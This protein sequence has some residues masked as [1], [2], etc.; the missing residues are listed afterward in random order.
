MSSQNSY[1]K[2][3]TTTTADVTVFGVRSFEEVMK[4]KIKSYGWVLIQYDLCPYK[5]RLAP[6][7]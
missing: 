3:F 1:G 5:K 6:D 2:V 4:V 7:T